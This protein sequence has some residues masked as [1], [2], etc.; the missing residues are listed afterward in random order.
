MQLC[1]P[2]E[3]I[4]YKLKEMGLVSEQLIMNV[5]EGFK[6]QDVDHSGTLTANIYQTLNESNKISDVFSSIADIL[7]TSFKDPILV[8]HRSRI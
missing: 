7:S 5:L 4:V 1:S 8:Q 2:A 3:Y 6:N